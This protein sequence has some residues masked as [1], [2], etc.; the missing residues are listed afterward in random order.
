M[1]PRP[2]AP[3]LHIAFEASPPK[4]PGWSYRVVFPGGVSESGPVRSLDD[5]A[6][7]FQRWGHGLTDLP[8]T[9]LPTF[10]GPAPRHTGGVWSWDAKRLLQG[11]SPGT[12]TL[13]PRSGD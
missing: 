2:E 8:W 10:G 1:S 9:E 13:V 6:A 11:D 12:A 7:V 4:G 5:L 3:A